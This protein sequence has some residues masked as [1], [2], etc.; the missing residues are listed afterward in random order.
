MSKKKKKNKQPQGKGGGGREAQEPVQVNWIALGL[1]V[2]GVAA[3]ALFSA[4]QQNPAASTSSSSSA[5]AVD[6]TNGPSNKQYPAAPPMTIDPAKQYMATFKLATGG[7]FDISLFA[8]QAP[9][10]VNNFVFL[11]RDGFYNC[12][13]FHR[14]LED[15][16][17]QGGDPTGAGTGGPGFQFQDEFSPDL[18]FDKPGL[19]AMANSGPGTNGSQFFI[20]FVP[21]PHLNN[22]HTIFGEVTRGMD[23]VNAITRR[24]PADPTAGPGDMIN[25]ITIVEQ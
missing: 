7:E 6:C 10:T 18:T 2:I 13:I 14:V 11:A 24:D 12:V 4:S 23:V 9:I 21:T 1:V 8:D 3:V 20:T 5:A 19:L 15:F 16:M 17:A 25:T 22:K